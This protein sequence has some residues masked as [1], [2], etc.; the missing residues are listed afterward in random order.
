[1]VVGKEPTSPPALPPMR[2]IETVAKMATAPATMPIWTTTTTGDGRKGIG[3]FR[4]GSD[5]DRRVCNE[6]SDLSMRRFLKAV[7]FCLE[8][9]RLIE[10]AVD[11]SAKED[12]WH[13]VV[14]TGGDA[15]DQI[16]E[17]RP[18]RDDRPGGGAVGE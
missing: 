4:I 6:L 7:H 2:S 12:G 18:R 3:K 15:G 1:M 14:V 5:L 10:P 9:R 11:L 16:E 13:V 17:P 8:F